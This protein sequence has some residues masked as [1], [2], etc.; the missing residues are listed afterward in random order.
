M[1]D[2]KAAI[3]G[4]AAQALRCPT[5]PVRAIGLVGG[6]G[7][8][9]TT[10]AVRGLAGLG[11]PVRVIDLGGAKDSAILSGHDFTYSA[12]RPGRIAEA[13]ITTGVMD[14]V[15]VFDELDKISGDVKGKEIAHVLM[16]LT[17][18]L[19]NATFVDT[20][21]ANVPLDLSRAMVVFTFNDEANVDAVLLDR[22]HVI[23][24]SEPTQA[25]RRTVVDKHMLP[26]LGG[27][28]V[29]VA[30]DGEASSAIDVVLSSNCRSSNSMRQ[31]EKVLERAFMT[32]NVREMSKAATSSSSTIT[33]GREDVERAAKSLMHPRNECTNSMYV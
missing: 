28:A 1:T 32:A 27:S 20:Y 19:R 16:A 18:P 4:I 3:L 5:A 17:D 14:P 25:E 15:L 12:S 2:A 31:I 6:P 11:R 21:F 29:T 7:C 22:M 24:I 10:L 30:L 33:L 26:R 13:I 8:G 23:R 9:K